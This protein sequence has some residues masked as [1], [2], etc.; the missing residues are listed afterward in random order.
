MVSVLDTLRASLAVDQYE[1]KSKVKYFEKDCHDIKEAINAAKDFATLTQTFLKTHQEELNDTQKFQLITE[2]KKMLLKGLKMKDYLVMVDLASDHEKAQL[3]EAKLIGADSH[4]ISDELIKLKLFEECRVTEFNTTFD[5]IIGIEDA[6]E[7]VKNIA[8]KPFIHKNI[9]SNTKKLNAALLFGAPG[10]GK[11]LL[12]FAAGNAI[13]K[14]G[15]FFKLSP[16]VIKKSIHGQTER[17]IKLF[18]QMA[19]SYGMAIIFIDEC[20][21]LC[22]QRTGDDKHGMS[23]KSVLVEELQMTKDWN[24]NLVLLGATN[25]PKEIG[26]VTFDLIKSFFSKK[27]GYF[28]HLYIS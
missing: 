8:V 2:A 10:T 22:S 15:H 4:M 24:K 21:S 1:L 18:F 5:Q 13:K 14:Y 28:I 12:A 11:S 27:K 3:E 17:H 23:I 19:R 7:A 16:E 9:A 20:D 25:L 6:K 26:T